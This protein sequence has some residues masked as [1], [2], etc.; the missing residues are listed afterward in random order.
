MKIGQ[1]KWRLVTFLLDIGSLV[2]AYLFSYYLRFLSGIASIFGDVHDRYAPLSVYAKQLI[3]LIPLYF[4]IY[5]VLRLIMINTNKK[6]LPEMTF[7][8][9]ANV[10]GIALFLT[11]LFIFK[12]FNISRWS[13]L[14]FLIINILLDTGFRV[15]ILR[16]QRM[17]AVHE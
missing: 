3:I 10:L 5:S 4:M 8:I 11:Y 13:L 7:V 17:V 9:L 6:I 1:N 12:E 16:V 15:I 14:M 2:F